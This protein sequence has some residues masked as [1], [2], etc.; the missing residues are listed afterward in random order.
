M[1]A[2]VLANVYLAFGAQG[3]FD[4]QDRSRGTHIVD[5]IEHPVFL[6]LDRM[7]EPSSGIHKPTRALRSSSVAGLQA[8]WLPLIN[9]INNV[10]LP[11][12]RPA[13]GAASEVPV[14]RHRWHP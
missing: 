8:N 9:A 7:R 11:F 12:M 13:F 2:I 10:R 6:E 1:R 5:E 14:I 3:P 4:P